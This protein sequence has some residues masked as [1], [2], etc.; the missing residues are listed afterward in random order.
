MA[1][2]T[3]YKFGFNT[4][5]GSH[6][7]V[8][9][10][11][12]GYA[13]SETE[14]T[15]AASPVTLSWDGDANDLFNPIRAAQGTFNV[16]GVNVTDFVSV[17]D[18]DW[19]AKVT[20]AGTVIYEGF[21]VGDD[22]PQQVIHG[23]APIQIN[24]TDGL[25]LLKDVI[26]PV[27]TTDQSLYEIINTCLSY[28]G[29][30][31]DLEWYANL[32]PTGITTGHWGDDVKTRRYY[33]I[34]DN[35]QYFDCYEILRQ[36]IFS[37]GCRIYQSGGRWVIDRPGDFEKFPSGVPGALYDSG[38]YDSNITLT[39]LYDSLIPVNRT[40]LK[41]V[42]RPVQAI[43]YTFDYLRPI[44][45]ENADLQQLG[46]FIGTVVDGSNT[47]YRYNAE[48]WT[49]QNSAVVEIRVVRNTT[50]DIEVD[51][52]LWSEFKADTPTGGTGTD[53]LCSNVIPIDQKDGFELSFSYK[54]EGSNGQTKRFYLAIGIELNTS[55]IRR[56]QVSQA[57]SQSQRV[58]FWNSA[59][60]S[61]V[62]TFADMGAGLTKDSPGSTNIETEPQTLRI[63][64]LDESGQ[65]KI[66]IFPANALNMKI[67]LQAFNNVSDSLPN[68]NARI[69]DIN[70]EYI[71]KINDQINII[72][73]YFATD[74]DGIS[75]K[76]RI[77]ENIYICDSPKILARGT[78]YTGSFALTNL[79]A[80]TAG[81]TRD[82]TWGEL[83]VKDR[84]NIQGVS[85]VLLEGD[86]KGLSFP[87]GKFE[88]D[89]FSGKT[90]LATRL[91]VDLINEIS[92]GSFYEVVGDDLPTLTYTTD[93]IYKV[94]R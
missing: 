87:K 80:T 74:A 5:S 93:Y 72:G 18:T 49:E 2:G 17:N 25:A 39:T 94:V 45:L 30:T 46:S 78:L 84:H 89:F 38:G 36:V 62:P 44:L 3:K 29:L 22:T 34:D 66:P 37:M 48:K 65:D 71:F 79:W 21:I 1:Y 53:A 42:Y 76:N 69:N 16:Y 40:Q 35:G 70:F 32:W 41:T 90:F 11:L 83:Q 75:F 50:T 7:I 28:T 57:T 92:T 27:Q 47:I 9:F 43:K 20:L 12:D 67:Y 6:C 13:G 64:E 15:G 58:L 54:G 19:K 31:Y 82:A 4:L 55:A 10:Q 77:S 52:Y 8:E 73:A 68:L 86:F 81:G 85:R 61:F 51:R 60:G 24:S 23:E 59:F 91:S 63:S 26:Y 33:L 14:I 88:F 56:L